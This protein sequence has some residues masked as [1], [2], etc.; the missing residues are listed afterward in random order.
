MNRICDIFVRL[1]L[2]NFIYAAVFSLIDFHPQ[3]KKNVVVASPCSGHGYKFCSGIGEV[4]SEMM[5][6]GYAKHD[7][8]LFKLR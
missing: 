8:S 7:I 5:T 2:L 6:D 3:F 1:S 4:I